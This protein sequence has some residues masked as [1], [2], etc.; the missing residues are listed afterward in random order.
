[1][2]MTYY[3][4]FLG[5][6]VNFAKYVKTEIIIHVYIYLYWQTTSPVFRTRIDVWR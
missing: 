4:L 2:T 6:L 3:I 5:L 1:M